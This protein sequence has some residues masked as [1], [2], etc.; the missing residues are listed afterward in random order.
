[1]TLED[2]YPPSE[3]CTCEVC[4][5][6]CKRPGWWTLHEAEEALDAGLA[7]RMMLEMAPELTFGVLSPAFTGC[8]VAF[9]TNL[10]A[11]NGC[12]FLLRDRCQLHGTGHQPLECRVCHHDRLGVGQQC[13]D[14]IEKEWN[15]PEGRKLVG[16][17]GKITGFWAQLNALLSADNKPA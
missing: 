1:M 12:S 7:G 4:I 13:H 10:H 6:F 8:E 17:W 11:P 15:T 16:K 3:P 2:K 9:A 5:G 14:D